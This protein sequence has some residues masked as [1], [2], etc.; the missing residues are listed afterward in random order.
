MCMYVGNGA[1]IKILE[2]RLNERSNRE[3]STISVQV[4]KLVFKDFFRL[5][6]GFKHLILQST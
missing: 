6:L 4:K 1:Y 3:L 5:I 2:A